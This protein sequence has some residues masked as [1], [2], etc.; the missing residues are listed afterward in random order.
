MSE[1]LFVFGVWS[2]VLVPEQSRLE[3]TVKVFDVDQRRSP[4]GLLA[5][6]LLYLL[7]QTGEFHLLGPDFPALVLQGQVAL[8]PLF[9]LPQGFQSMRLCCEFMALTHFLL[10]GLTGLLFLSFPGLTG[11]VQR[12]LF[13]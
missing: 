4:C 11:I 1:I 12:L 2:H 5:L 6:V 3:G 10:G 13:C 7:A 9:L 8:P